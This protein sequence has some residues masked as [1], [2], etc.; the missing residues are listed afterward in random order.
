MG[1]Y[2]PTTFNKEK[3]MAKKTFKIIVPKPAAANELGTDTKLYVADE[4]VEAKE[5]WQQDVMNTFVENGW[6]MEVK[7]ETGAE[8]TSEPVRA[9]NEDGTL[10]GDDPDTPDVNEAWEGGKAPKK[11]STAKKTTKKRTTKK[12]SS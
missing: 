11:K 8:E 12:K 9:R 7:A 4:L 1:V 6:A 3:D 2:A 5:D 10:K